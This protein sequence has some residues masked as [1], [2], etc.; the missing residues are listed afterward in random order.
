MHVDKGLE[1]GTAPLLVIPV[2]PSRRAI[3]LPPGLKGWGNEVFKATSLTSISI[4]SGVV[5]IGVAMFSECASL[6]SIHIPSR[7]TEFKHNAFRACKS[8]KSVSGMRGLK[9]IG[10]SAFRACELLENFTIPSVLG[11]M[12][13]FQNEQPNH[14]D[15][16]MS[17]E[18]LARRFPCL[19]ELHDAVFSAAA[20]GS[21][22][23]MPSQWH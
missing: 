12:Q 19:E 15:K 5:D 20:R 17:W 7:V 4:P 10:D 22:I 9:E 6:Q 3:S 16:T 11:L 18:T 13:A 23:V 2:S 8:L 1:G 21:I 14:T